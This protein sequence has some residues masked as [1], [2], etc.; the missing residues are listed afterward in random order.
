MNS[1]YTCTKHDKPNNYYEAV[2]LLSQTVP[3][4]FTTKQ[5]EERANAGDAVSEQLDH[6]SQHPQHGVGGE[7]HICRVHV[8]L[9]LFNVLVGAYKKQS[10]L[11]CMKPL[12]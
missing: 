11:D 4:K 8:G 9:Q 6:S 3:C 1:E 12:K 2:E 5:L 10:C 7:H